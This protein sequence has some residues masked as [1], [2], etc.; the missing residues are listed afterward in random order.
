MS[1]ACVLTH[2]AGMERMTV[3][4]RLRLWASAYRQIDPANLPMAATMDEAADA[5]GL[6]ES[7]PRPLPALRSPL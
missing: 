5:L 7:A 4:K 1:K 2:P 6:A 3:Q